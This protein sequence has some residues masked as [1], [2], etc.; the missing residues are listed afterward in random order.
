MLAFHSSS[1]TGT[2]SHTLA[3]QHHFNIFFTM[4]YAFD[5]RQLC[6]L[7]TAGKDAY[8]VRAEKLQA[9][10]SSEITKGKMPLQK[11]GTVPRGGHTE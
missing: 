5:S 10:N 7:A 8:N 9:L 3:N 2:V 11:E 4:A 6:Y 1:T